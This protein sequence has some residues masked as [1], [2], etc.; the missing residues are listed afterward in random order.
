[1]IA[2][3][4]VLLL[5]I[6][7]PLIW[8]IVIYNL[9]V[10]D[11]T[12]VLTA[13]SDIDV[14]LKRRHDVIPKLVDAVKQYAAFESAT[15]E[16]VTQLRTESEKLSDVKQKGEIETAITHSLFN[17]LAI[18]EDYPDLKASESFL[19]LQHELTDI[20]NTIQYARRYYNG[21]VRNLNIRIDSFPDLIIANI[22]NFEKADFFDFEEKPA[23]EIK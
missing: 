11:K 20:E 7:L 16:A 8:F 18:A 1:M 4:E 17:I 3:L 12:R 10:R 14:Q 9:L 13:W 15:L 5:I 6:G 19:K 22:F 2:Y 23:S 21:A